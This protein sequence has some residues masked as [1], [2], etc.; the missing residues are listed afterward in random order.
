MIVC[1]P[2]DS[3]IKLNM[4]ERETS[5][6]TSRANNRI[7]AAQVFSRSASNLRSSSIQCTDQVRQVLESRNSHEEQSTYLC[8]VASIATDLQ[9]S[10]SHW[11]V[12][13]V[14]FLGIPNVF[15]QAEDSRDIAVRKELDILQ[16][17]IEELNRARATVGA[18]K[19]DAI[20]KRFLE[21]AESRMIAEKRGEDV[22]ITEDCRKCLP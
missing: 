17:R 9:S 22:N 14:M 3:L 4:T 1:N 13:F 12:F 5:T 19:V 16:H 15:G 20:Q 11:S 8:D 2:L 6:S 18:A 7:E 10:R 21:Q